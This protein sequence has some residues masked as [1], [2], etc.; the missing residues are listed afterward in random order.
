[1][2]ADIKTELTTIFGAPQN[3]I[4]LQKFCDAMAKA[5]VENIQANALVTGT[6]T[7]GMGAGGTV[8]GTVG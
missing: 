3:A 6:V 7:S 5:I 1:M 8:T 2:S 4:E